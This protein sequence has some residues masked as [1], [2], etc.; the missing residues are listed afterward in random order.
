MSHTSHTSGRRNTASAPP[1]AVLPPGEARALAEALRRD[2]EPFL[3]PGERFALVTEADAEY[4][5][6]QL[7]LRRA[8]RREQLTLEAALEA[9]D[10]AEG[11]E[12]PEPRE[13][14][15]LLMTFLRA[16]LYEYF[17]QDRTLRFPLDWTLAMLDHL[18]IKTRGERTSPL[19]EAQADAL[20]MSSEDEPLEA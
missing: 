14:V 18:V 4:V 7:V 12:L 16:Q 20:L 1:A 11:V 17:R 6:A 15:R 8:D 13:V 5:L 10:Q 9:V 2:F 19:L 3:R